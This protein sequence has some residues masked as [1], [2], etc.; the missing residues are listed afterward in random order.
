MKDPI[1]S[2]GLY[3]IGTVA[4]M[5][6]ITPNLLRAWERR[7]Q[8]MLPDRQAGNQRLYSEQDVA[9]LR[10]ATALVARGLS[11]GEVASL[12]REKLLQGAHQKASHS[13]PS[14]QAAAE[15]STRLPAVVT[16]VSKIVGQ[17]A[18]RNLKSHRQERY[19]GESLEVCLAQ[20]PEDLQPTVH[21]IYGLTKSLYEL[22]TYMERRIAAEFVYRRLRQLAEPDLMAQIQQMLEAGSRLRDPL[23][24]G[25]IEDVCCGALLPLQQEALRQVESGFDTDSLNLAVSLARDHSKMMRNA[26][27]D[28]DA[29]LRE[30]DEHPRA[31]DFGPIAQKLLPLRGIGWVENVATDYTGPISCRCLEVS[32]LDRVLYRFL[33]P[34]TGL[35]A[36]SSQMKIWI[37]PIENQLLRLAFQYTDKPN[38]PTTSSFDTRV[39]AQAMGVSFEKAIGQGYIGSKKMGSSHWAWFHWPLYQVPPHVP[40]CQCHPIESPVT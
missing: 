11:I 17:L 12:G 31:H 2:K 18:P 28:L 5:V 34:A 27:R 37:V 25:A 38:A 7:Y 1:E 8:M 21:K 3:K 9:V 15:I 39:V 10:A 6:G 35:K 4:S 40:H 33:Q 22:W 26:L 20:L 30:A 16:E 13:S 29:T 36:R 19:A 14:L 32:A 24:R 23:V